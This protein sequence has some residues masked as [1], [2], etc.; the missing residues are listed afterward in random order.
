MLK[1]IR[2]RLT[3]AN[4]A[5]T[6]ALVFAMSGG[7]Y[8]ANRYLI[9]STKQ[10]SPKVLK[11]LKGATGKNGAA[12]PSGPAG[13][14]GPTGAQGGSGPQGAP[15]AP[16]AGGKEGAPG[17]SVTS[18]EVKVGETACNKL[19]G[20]SFTV[21]GKTEFACNGSPW[22]AGGTLPKGASETGV[23]AFTQD[24]GSQA[25]IVSMSFPIKLASELSEEQVH[26]IKEGE[27]APSG[28]T[29]SAENPGAEKGN[30]CVFT[31]S[32]VELGTFEPV[33]RVF[34]VRNPE[35]G[36]PGAGKS[37]AFMFA[38]TAEAPEQIIGNGVWVVTAE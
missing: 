2:K 37:G 18:K 1:M 21:A 8:A 30:L 7:A 32:I 14:A 13:P 26:Y 17:Q 36:A 16:G 4:L 6:L 35:L 28:C 19:G 22:T 29:G 3:Y 24:K 10:I 34:T 25:A 20:S 23:W 12:G 38:A 33:E 15:G 9:T 31:K 27:A 5:M 11:T